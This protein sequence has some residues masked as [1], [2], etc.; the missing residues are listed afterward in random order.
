MRPRMT[1]RLRP[2]TTDA[3]PSAVV[4]FVLSGFSSSSG[5]EAAGALG[6]SADGTWVTGAGGGVAG[7]V[8]GSG[9]AGGAPLPWQKPVPESVK[10]PPAVGRNCQSYEAG[11]SVS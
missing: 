11:C 6:M 7:G 10:L 9:G 4:I 5:G 2:R 1:R 8:D 3:T